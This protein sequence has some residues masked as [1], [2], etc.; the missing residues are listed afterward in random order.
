MNCAR[1][2]KRMKIALCK[3][4][5]QGPISG[6]DETLVTYA[7]ELRGAGHD[8]TVL[9]L[10]PFSPS[11]NFYRRL[12]LADVPVASIVERAWLFSALRMAREMATHVLFVFIIFSRFPGHVRK[13][14]QSLLR[15]I[16][17]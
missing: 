3:S 15:L 9:L 2:P 17:R 16:S 4:S 8:V 10:Y 6:A 12:R 7:T 14:W 1:P 13:L 5:F 11:D